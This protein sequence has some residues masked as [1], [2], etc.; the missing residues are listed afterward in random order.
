[1]AP[2]GGLRPHGQ[3]SIRPSTD[4]YQ[5]SLST[6]E[7]SD[8]DDDDI[9]ASKL[10]VVSSS[11]RLSLPL[12]AARLPSNRA[13]RSLSDTARDG[14][15]LYPGSKK[16]RNGYNMAPVSRESLAPSTS[17]SLRTSIQT[18]SRANSLSSGDDVREGL[19][20]SVNDALRGLQARPIRDDAEEQLESEGAPTRNLL[21]E[22]ESEE[23]DDAGD[24]V[25]D[26]DSRLPLDTPRQ[27]SG[28]VSVHPDIFSGVLQA[29]HSARVLGEGTPNRDKQAEPEIKTRVDTV[30]P[31]QGDMWAISNSPGQ[32]IISGQ[33]LPPVKRRGRPPKLPARTVLEGAPDT[34]KKVGRPRKYYPRLCDETDEEYLTRI[35]TLRKK[36]IPSFYDSNTQ[37]SQQPS[38]VTNGTAPQIALELD[39]QPKSEPDED[40][41]WTL[42]HVEPGARET[43]VDRAPC[44][45]DKLAQHEPTESNDDRPTN[46]NVEESDGT[47]PEFIEGFDSDIDQSEGSFECDVNAFKAHQTNHPEDEEVFETP[48]DDDVL[49]VH[50]DDQPLKQLCQLLGDRSWAGVKNGW[51]S[52]YF[53]YEHA[54]TKPARAILPLLTKLERLYQAAPKAPNLSEQNQFLRKHADMLRH[55]FYKIKMVVQHIRNERLSIPE[56]NETVQN[57]NPRKRKRMTRDLVLYVVPMLAHVLASAWGLGGKTWTNN[58]P[59]QSSF[60]STV[61][62]LLKRVL[63]WIMVLHPR[64]LSELARCPFEDEPK[65]HR[66]KRAWHERNDRREHISPLLDDLYQNISA[67]PD[68][69]LDAEAHVEE[70][71]KRR[72]QQLEREKQLKIEQKAAEEARQALVAE[73][74]KQSLLSIR[75]IHNRLES[76]ATSSLPSSSVTL[77]SA[78]WSIEEQR[79]LFDRLQASFPVCPDLNDLR[80]EL[81]KTVAQTVAMT[82]QLLQKMLKKVLIGY[83]TEERTAKLREIMHTSGVVGI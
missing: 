64:L 11:K 51:Q 6:A 52:R 53:R 76:P 24:N 2:R 8:G 9:P 27:T 56:H 16:P 67:A 23:Q 47:L 33:R 82:E 68:L 36:P 30:L 65:H 44:H 12:S 34:K 7:S 45:D 1:M 28:T 70:E 26:Q 79:L 20:R 83:S 29:T 39:L 80:W 78:G 35:A 63:G 81:N 60:T 75:A 49:A 77:Q 48:S 43:S 55:Y 54:Q 42:N 38:P 3:G 71:L 46:S 21:N 72:Q 15:V 37:S 4:P 59:R 66:A 50:L 19:I 17:D 31:P 32:P 61:V 10:P 18:R 57:T 14:I 74:K 69:L 25:D 41:V 73:R 58:S 62:E 5:C 40:A 13:K 22:A